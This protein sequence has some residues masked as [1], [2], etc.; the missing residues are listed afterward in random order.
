MTQRLSISNLFSDPPSFTVKAVNKT[1]NESDEVTFHC[2][3]IGNPAPRI[4]WI[5]DGKTMGS[6]E[7]LRFTA[8]RNDS[9]MYLCSVDNGMN[10]TVKARTY[11]NVQCKF[12]H[13]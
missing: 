1:V 4:T 8:L 10:V 7:T 6:G 9:G 12:R 5:K 11:L 2:S 3:A 13:S